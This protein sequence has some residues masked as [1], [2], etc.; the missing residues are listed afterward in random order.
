MI[1]LIM[2]CGSGTGITIASDYMST[3]EQ[4]KVIKHIN[5]SMLI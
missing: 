4:L 3:D 1:I 5:G 2:S